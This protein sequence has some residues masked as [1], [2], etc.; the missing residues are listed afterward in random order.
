MVRVE[1][2]DTS[3]DTDVK[4]FTKKQHH[5][6]GHVPLCVMNLMIECWQWH[7]GVV[8]RDGS[9]YVLNGNTCENAKFCD[10]LWSVYPQTESKRIEKFHNRFGNVHCYNASELGLLCAIVSKWKRF[11]KIVAQCLPFLKYCKE[12][13][14]FKMMDDRDDENYRAFDAVRLSDD[15]LNK[16]CR[17]EHERI[18]LTMACIELTKLS[19]NA[20][21][22]DCD[23]LPQRTDSA[24]ERLG[25]IEHF[26]TTL[27]SK[28]TKD[29]SQHSMEDCKEECRRMK[30]LFERLCKQRKQSLLWLVNLPDSSWYEYSKHNLE[31]TESMLKWL[32]ACR[33]KTVPPHMIYTTLLSINA[34]MM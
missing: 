16:Y 23:I 20:V 24:D 27:S 28:K 1:S 17:T 3:C 5:V 12:E 4:Y 19:L 6:I 15:T 30:K 7:M 2:C 32:S 33:T 14:A 22:R 21:L 8:A 31:N 25:F 13:T 29:R 26:L 11:A 10:V 9:Y 18:F 34:S